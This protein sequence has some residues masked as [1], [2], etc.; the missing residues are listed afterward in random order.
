MAHVAALVFLSLQMGAALMVETDQFPYGIEHSHWKGMAPVKDFRSAPRENAY[1]V[2]DPAGYTRFETAM[3]GTLLDNKIFSG[4]D[5]A[6]TE[7][8]AE[9]KCVGITCS[10]HT[11]EC[12]LREAFGGGAGTLMTELCM[13]SYRK[14]PSDDPSTWLKRSEK[15]RLH[16]ERFLNCI[17]DSEQTLKD[18]LLP[19]L[20]GPEGATC[21]GMTTQEAITQLEMAYV[22][23]WNDEKHQHEQVD[24]FKPVGTPDLEIAKVF[25]PMG[26]W[27]PQEKYVDA[28]ALQK[29]RMK[30]QKRFNPTNKSSCKCEV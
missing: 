3:L 23:A 4:T 25:A 11:D 30:A 17:P 7:C 26:N 6:L 19:L 27:A 12:G 24:Y 8:T 2:N 21:D 18:C 10:R 16:D 5:E 9:P 28:T 29:A 14:H 22:P 20:G 1:T 13:F 15:K